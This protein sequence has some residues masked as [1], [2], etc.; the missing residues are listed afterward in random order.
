MHIA[1]V[2]GKE[3]SR[4]LRQLKST[5]GTKRGAAFWFFGEDLRIDWSGA[6]LS[7]GARVA[8][9][10]RQGIVV[11]GDV[12][13]H[14]SAR[15]NYDGPT[16]IRFEDNAL[17]IGR[18]RIPARRSLVPRSVSLPVD[19]QA[20]DVLL[21]TLGFGTQAMSDSGYGSDVDETLS[22]LKKNLANS[23]RNLAW[24]SM[25][26]DRLADIIMDDLIA[27]AH[28][29][30]ERYGI[31]SAK[32]RWE[33]PSGEFH[34]DL[35]ARDEEGLIYFLDQEELD[36]AG[37]GRF[38]IH[39]RILESLVTLSKR[40]KR[41]SNRAFTIYEGRLRLGPDQYCIGISTTNGDLANFLREEWARP[42]M[43]GPNMNDMSRLEPLFRYDHGF[44]VEYVSDEHPPG[45]PVEDVEGGLCP[46][47]V[48]YTR[49]YQRI[50][51]KRSQYGK[52]RKD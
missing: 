24:T 16:E 39:R 3:L 15:L 40:G 27:K 22:R 7:L 34:C 11:A 46:G 29:V 36:G 35:I 8:E 1:R 9:L 52:L 10:A 26:P 13:K 20:A 5:P 51:G 28:R 33:Y 25:A 41:L 2:D 23:A 50:A 4:V 17:L 42:R 38:D 37:I 21:A 30:K 18:D 43:D 14:L 32:P 6:S 45:T 49:H 44:V 19:A 47:L 12:M 31:P 48:S